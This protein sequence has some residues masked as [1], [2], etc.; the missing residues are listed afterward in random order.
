[1]K[2]GDGWSGNEVEGVIHLFGLT[3]L[4]PRSLHLIDGK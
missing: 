4:S 1:L 2:E 3:P